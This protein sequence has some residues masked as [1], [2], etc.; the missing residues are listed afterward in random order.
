MPMVSAVTGASITTTSAV[1][2]SAGRSLTGATPSRARLATR[3]T[4]TSN[5]AS[6]RSTAW[7]I[8]PYPTISTVLAARLS[9]NR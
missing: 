7:P 4:S 1:G 6:R 3:L 8:D 2:S 5:P 9:V